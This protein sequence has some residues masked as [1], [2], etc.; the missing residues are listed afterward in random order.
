MEEIISYLQSLDL[1]L[2]QIG[3]TAGVLLLGTLLL[4]AFGRFVF[5]KRSVLNNAVSSA[6]GILFIYTISVLL[7]MGGMDLSRF[8]APLPLVQISGDTMHL[9]SFQGA[10]Y[11]SICSELL[12]MIILSFLVNLADGWMPKGKNIFSWLLFRVLTVALGYLMHLIV[13][14]LLAKYLPEG[15]LIYAPVIL[16]GLLVLL[17]LTGALKLVVGAALT[18]INPIIGGLYTFFFATI[19]GKQI[20]RSVLTTAILSGLIYGLS[21][22][23]ITAISIASAALLAYIPFGIL[24]IVL[25]YI[26]YKVF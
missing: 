7:R 19:I 8:I 16:L 5:G 22:L 14:G 4:G 25:W 20:T 24:L 10:H 26:V 18:T 17:L 21:Y 23:G 6:I 2:Y 11:T 3:I 9:F 15:I 12:N 13:V 1:D